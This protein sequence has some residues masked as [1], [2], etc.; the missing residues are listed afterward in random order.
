MKTPGAKCSHQCSDE[1][2]GKPLVHLR[3]PEFQNVSH[4]FGCP[5]QAIV[6][7]NQAPCRKSLRC[8][9]AGSARQGCQPEE[10]SAPKKAGDVNFALPEPTTETDRHVPNPRQVKRSTVLR[11][12]VPASRAPPAMIPQTPL[13]SGRIVFGALIPLP[14]RDVCALSGFYLGRCCVK[15]AA[16]VAPVTSQCCCA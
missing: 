9:F 13:E 1:R 12:I 2:P 6:R 10:E 8:A 5:E 11:A 14:R 15:R 3:T 16:R 4:P 7:N